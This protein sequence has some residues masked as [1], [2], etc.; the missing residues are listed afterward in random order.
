MMYYYCLN[1]LAFAEFP[2]TVWVRGVCS[3][4]FIWFYFSFTPF[5]VISCCGVAPSVITVVN[6]GTNYI[7]F[8]IISIYIRFVFQLDITIVDIGV[9]I[10]YVLNSVNQT[11]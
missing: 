4:V 6:F 1:I 10:L 3:P 11:Y 5:T 7:K 2:R 8:C 9:Y